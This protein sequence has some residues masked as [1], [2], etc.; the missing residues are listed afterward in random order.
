M[1]CT[2]CG[3]KEA[4]VYYKQN[5]NGKITEYNVCPDCAA[6]LRKQYKETTGHGFDSVFGG[7]DLNLIGSLL[8]LPTAARLAPAKTCPLC[9]ATYR[10]FASGGKAGCAKCYDVF[11]SELSRTII[12]IHGR[13][14]HTGRTPKGFIAQMSLEKKIGTLRDKLKTA[15]ED[16]AFEEAAKLR[17]EIRTLE[18]ESES[19]N[20]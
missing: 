11:R 18:S 13:R 7:D 16:Q 2:K 3:K 10:D 4:T 1:L 5:I 6:E 15:I 14:E 9:G 8:G 19:E 12:G 17:D 20:R